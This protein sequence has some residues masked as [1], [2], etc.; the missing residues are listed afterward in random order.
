VWLLL[1]A[2]IAS[3]LGKLT[4]VTY[5]SVLLAGVFVIV[6]YVNPRF[7][8]E[9]WQTRIGYLAGLIAVAYVGYVVY[10]FVE[11]LPGVQ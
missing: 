9:P 11:L 4:I 10:R 5:T 2:V 3:A 7:V 8:N 6:E 1:A